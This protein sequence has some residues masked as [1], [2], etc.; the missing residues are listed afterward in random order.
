MDANTLRKAVEAFYHDVW[1]R[2]DKSMI[3]ELLCADIK[4]RGSLGQYRV[5]HEGFADYLDEVHAALGDYRCEILDLVI[6]DAKVFARMRFSGIHR[7][8]LLGYAP[9][10]QRIEWAGAALFLFRDGKIADLWVLGDV[11][12]VL[13]DMSRSRQQEQDS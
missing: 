11:H 7:G 10:G 13:A 4:F 9:S 6:D 8:E 12:G 3:P 2:H 5:G 1:N